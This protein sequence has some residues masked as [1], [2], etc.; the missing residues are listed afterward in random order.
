MKMNKHTVSDAFATDGRNGAGRRAGAVIAGRQRNHGDWSL[1]PDLGL[2]ERPPLWLAI[3]VW[4]MRQRRAVT[5]EDVAQAFR[6]SPRRA[7]DM[8]TYIMRI[9]SGTVLITKEVIRLGGGHRVA[10]FTVDAV[11]PPAEA[12]P[13]PKMA[14]PKA[15][16]TAKKCAQ[17]ALA[18][19]RRAFLFQRRAGP[20]TP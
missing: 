8:L 17:E 16:K 2:G 7:A 11:K 14:R 15:D 19:A 1:P 9:C 13:A 5:R 20:G 6:I 12:G 4:I 10:R 18:Q 3:S